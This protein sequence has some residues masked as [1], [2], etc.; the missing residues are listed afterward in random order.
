VT[1]EF[2]D[3]WRGLPGR[4]AL[5]VDWQ[6]TWRNRVRD[7]AE[8]AARFAPKGNAPGRYVSAADAKLARQ[9]APSA[10]G[11][12]MPPDEP[13]PPPPPD[14]SRRSMAVLGSYRA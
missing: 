14:A 4:A 1:D 12:L 9:N 8:R 7:K 3:Y 2:C 10:F 13:E 6:I 5:K 11:H